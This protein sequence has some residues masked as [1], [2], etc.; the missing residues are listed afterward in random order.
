MSADLTAKRTELIAMLAEADTLMNET[1]RNI[2]TE[3]EW[4]ENK[5]RPNALL[6]DIP[7]KTKEYIQAVKKE[8]K[9]PV[10]T[11]TTETT[12]AIPGLE[13]PSDSIHQDI[14]K[15]TPLSIKELKT[16]IKQFQKAWDNTKS[17]RE[18]FCKVTK[19]IGTYKG[20]PEAYE[21][22][23][24]VMGKADEELFSMK[25]LLRLLTTF[26]DDYKN[27]TQG[28][29]FVRNESFEQ[30]RHIG[31]VFQGLIDLRSKFT[32]Y[33]EDLA[34]SKVTTASIEEKL[35]KAI[36]KL[37]TIGEKGP[38]TPAERVEEEK[39]RKQGEEFRL[40]PLI[41]DCYPYGSPP[42]AETMDLP[43]LTIKPPPTTPPASTSIKPEV[44]E[45][46]S[47][48]KDLGTGTGLPPAEEEEDTSKMTIREPEPTTPAQQVTNKAI[49][50]QKVPGKLRQS[51]AT[52]LFRKL[53]RRK[54]PLSSVGQGRSRKRTLKKRRAGK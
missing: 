19:D 18:S 14:L 50:F 20:G 34:K 35:K 36:E 3:A 45:S 40:T 44:L 33:Q 11:T 54:K 41:T 15:T 8:P 30:E 10:A 29:A 53:T 6:T 27:E 2:N 25:K 9:T 48:Y 52:K 5:E 49:G 12:E 13:K 22:I 51:P 24:E 32:K 23:T 1:L 7:K 43:T 28:I 38:M 31:G 39:I 26:L 4:N 21:R 46:L 16:R 47:T 37:K 17:A 42:S